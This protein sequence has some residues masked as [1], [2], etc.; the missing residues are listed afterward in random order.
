M[1]VRNRDRALA[2]AEGAGASRVYKMLEQSRRELKARLESLPDTADGTFTQARLRASLAQIELVMKD[3]VRQ[4]K[5]LGQDQIKEASELG[6][7]DSLRYLKEMEKRYSGVAVPLGLDR[8][9]HF[10]H[11]LRGVQSSLLRQFPTSLKRYGA[12]SIE[13]FEGVLQQ[14]VLQQR[15]MD[16]VIESIVNSDKFFEGRRY[17]AERLVRTETLNAYGS[18]SLRSIKE[19]GDDWPDMRKV[20][21]GYF[22]NRT[23]PDTFVLDGQTRKPN[24]PF[25]YRGKGGQAPGGMTRPPFMNTPKRPNCRC[26]T[27]AWRP[28]WPKPATRNP[29]WGDVPKG[30]AEPAAELMEEGEE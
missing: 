2:L 6:M 7:R 18:G 22:D 17:W 21:V 25:R 5:G 9:A 10:D 12:D 4:L 24:E 26:V 15:P 28:G 23:G 30:K 3:V 8:A 16:A 19:A 11:S 29:L 14:G 13:K 1:L 20:L 27:V